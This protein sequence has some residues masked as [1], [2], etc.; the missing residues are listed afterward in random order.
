ML[1][2]LFPVVKT[3]ARD[4]DISHIRF[5]TA[6]LRGIGSVESLFRSAV[7]KALGTVNRRHAEVPAAEFLGMEIS[8]RLTVEYLENALQSL[9]TGGVYELMCHPGHFDPQEVSDARLMDYHDWEGELR[10]LTSP[11]ARALLDRRGVRLIGFR[12]LVTEDGRLAV[13]SELPA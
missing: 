13:R 5:P 7:I 1:P 6:R 11:A 2:G 10:T 4:Y 9:R 12:H 8:G 3:L